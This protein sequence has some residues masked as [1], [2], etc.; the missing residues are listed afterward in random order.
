MADLAGAALPQGAATWQ[1]LPLLCSAPPLGALWGCLFAGTGRVTR[2]SHP[3]QL[4]DSL[5]P[6]APRLTHSHKD[7]G[8]QELPHFANEVTQAVNRL[9]ERFESRLP[10]GQQLGL[11]FSGQPPG[12]GL[13]L[14]HRLEVIPGELGAP[15]S[16]RLTWSHCKGWG[17]VSPWI[18]PPSPWDPRMLG[19]GPEQP[20]APGLWSLVP[21]PFWLPGLGSPDSPKDEL[22]CLIAAEDGGSPYPRGCG[23]NTTFVSNRQ[24][25]LRGYRAQARLGQGRGPGEALGCPA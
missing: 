19:G 23:S 1:V 3:N 7:P 10:S 4:S 12:Q 6:L 20:Q 14:L 15:L 8:R 25:R 24:W 13:S 9:P 16:Q 18:S 2:G 17:I 5:S 11:F 22:S 21:G